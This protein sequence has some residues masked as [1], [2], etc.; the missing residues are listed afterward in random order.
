[1]PATKLTWLITG[2]SSGLGKSIASQALK[3]GY[4]VIATTRDVS[5]A[6]AAYPDFASKGG[7]WICL[8]PAQ[9][10]AY[11]QF[12]KYSEEYNVDVLVNNAGY[13]FVGGVE[14]TSE[15][16]VRDQM[17]VNF[18]GPLRAVR[19]CLPVMRARGSG[20]IILI[21]S[22]AGFVARPG[23][24]AYS[25][26][27]FGIEAVHE[28]LSNEVR[29]LGIKVLIVEPGA[30]RT[31][32]LSRI[33]TPSCL[34]NGFSD[35]YKGTVVE[36]IVTGS[37]QLTSIPDF[38]RGDPDKAAQAV[39]NAIVTGYDYLRLPLGKDCVVA[40]ES[41]IRQLLRDLGTTRAVAISTDVD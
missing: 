5:R 24:S 26:S 28:S 31:P 14:D 19:A 39:I 27:K 25:A 12:A 35:G 37:R 41:K 30:F 4:K 38:I 7:I 23:R 32:F 22:G 40:L 3:A 8:D 10:D 33:I 20:H 29:T 13:A 6:E 2:A 21:S 1:M 34:E 11:D 17:E 9:N 18:Y 16:E 15:A 36:H